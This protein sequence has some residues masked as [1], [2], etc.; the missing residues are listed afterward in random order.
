[1]PMSTSNS[2]RRCTIYIDGFNFYFGIFENKPEWKWLNIQ[3]FFEML[4]SREDVVSIKYFTAIVDPKKAY[5]ARRDRQL[6][7]LKALETLP[8]VEI[9]NGVFQPRTVRCDAKCCEQYIVSQEKKTDVNITIRMIQDCL[10][11]A[12]DSVVLVSG[13]SDQEPAIHWIHNRFQD[14]ALAVYIPVLEQERDS[15]RNDFYYSI[16]VPCNP[17]P[18]DGLAAHQLPA[19]IKFFN[20]GVLQEVVQRPTEWAAN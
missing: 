20:N 5:S 13:D 15:R 8:K 14:I 1:M 16:G 19:V 6:L 17:L 11:K 18:L 10:E 3:S 2:S 9:I 7:F 12:T 4:R